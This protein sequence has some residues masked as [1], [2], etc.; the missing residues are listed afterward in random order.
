[1]AETGFTRLSEELVHDGPVIK[2]YLA[3]IEAPDGSIMDREI[4]RHP[5]AV[6]V[7]PIDG[8]EVIMLR[9]YRAPIDD[10]LLEIPAGKRDVADEPPEVTARRELIEEIGFDC[11]T[12]VPLGEFLNTAGFCD[13]Y[14]YIYLATDLI[15][16]ERE[17]DGAEEQFMEIVRYPLSQIPT[18]VT[19]RTVIDAKTLLGLMWAIP[20][21]PENAS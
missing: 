1:M 12:L 7:V 10:L 2:T 9:Q 16:A 17:F 18:M 13:E 4:S 3:M 8:D 15:P 11:E 20:H 19:D 14:T 5:G 6:A 21:L